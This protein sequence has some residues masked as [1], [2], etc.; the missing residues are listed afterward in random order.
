M[1]P[2]LSACKLANFYEIP[3]RNKNKKKKYQ[4]QHQTCYQKV[5]NLKQ[6]FFK[7]SS[8]LKVFHQFYL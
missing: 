3:I 5:S 2:P 4:E 1:H 6:R 7:S 8:V